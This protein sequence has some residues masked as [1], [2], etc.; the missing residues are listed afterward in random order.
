MTN[1]E[2]I[3][4]ANLSLS[5]ES[6]TQQNKE[7]PGGIDL[8]LLTFRKMLEGK[9]Y[10]IQSDNPETVRRVCA[11]A[12]ALG[13]SPS[14]F[15]QSERDTV[16]LFAPP[17]RNQ[18]GTPRSGPNATET[19]R[20]TPLRRPTGT[21]QTPRVEKAASIQTICHH[22]CARHSASAYPSSSRNSTRELRIRCAKSDGSAKAGLGK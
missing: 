22:T 10:A 7:P 3:E 13:V 15:E 1:E 17:A 5:E 20:P 16:M 12:A 4:L 14:R 19:L 6:A 18:A 9:P 8:L 11:I 21:L 2:T